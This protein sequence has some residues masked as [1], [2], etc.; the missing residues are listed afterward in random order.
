MCRLFA[1]IRMKWIGTT[2][3]FGVYIDKSM[4]HLKP[5]ATLLLLLTATPVVAE[6]RRLDP[7]KDPQILLYDFRSKTLSPNFGSAYYENGT[8][9][10]DEYID[11]KSITKIGD[12]TY[13]NVYTRSHYKGYLL[14]SQYKR[15]E[16]MDCTN[17][18]KHMMLD[19]KEVL[20]YNF[21]RIVK[22]LCES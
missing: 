15:S 22:M 7:D 18:T 13:F 4:K 12:T 10:V 14:W 16:Q 17:P 2:L 6:E 11:L 19:R 20:Y 3:S 5:L 1:Q 21:N 8:K 9:R